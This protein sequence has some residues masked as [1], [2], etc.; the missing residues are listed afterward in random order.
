VAL[1]PDATFALA[2]DYFGMF[3]FN[4]ETVVEDPYT[5]VME[6]SQA[7]SPSIA[8]DGRLWA[9]FDVE[10]TS[11][12]VMERD[13]GERRYTFTLPADTCVDSV[14]SRFTPDGDL[15]ALLCDD[16]SLHFWDVRTGEHVRQLDDS[17]QGF[18]F[19]GDGRLLITTTYSGEVIFW[20][21]P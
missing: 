12:V 2:S 19:S 4:P 7:Y 5:D 17:I 16:G 14:Q 13:S 18:A 1:S 8:P 15:L 6:L 11:M 21:V 9:Y 20:G 3:V 10:A